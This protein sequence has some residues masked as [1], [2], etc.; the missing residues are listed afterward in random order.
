[1]APRPVSRTRAFLTR[2]TLIS[3][4]RLYIFPVMKKLTV[5]IVFAIAAVAAPAVLFGQEVIDR[6]DVSSGVVE[7]TVT[8]Q[9]LRFT[10]DEIRVREGVTVRLTYENGGGG[11]DWVLDELD[12]A[13][14]FLRGGQS[15]TIEFV[16]DEAGTF[17]FYCSVPGHRARGMVGDFVVV[18]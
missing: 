11:H 16:A 15:E 9:G 6:T 10:P 17:E 13:T 8:S 4:R 18:R 7:I 12:A 14:E 1:V 3:G 2:S 5:L